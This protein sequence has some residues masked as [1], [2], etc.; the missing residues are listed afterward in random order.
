MSK[1]ELPLCGF[2]F[3][4]DL[5][6]SDVDIY[7]KGRPKRNSWIGRSLTLLYAGIY[8]FFFIFRVVRMANKVDV[9]FYDIYAFNGQPPYMKINNE[10]F[11]S[12]FALLHPLT[13]EPYVNPSIY[14]VKMTYS[15]GVKVGAAFNFETS[16]V[17]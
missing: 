17:E 8:I 13:Q 2:F 14:N 16:N 12:G 6:G 11:R 7:Y 5:F 10:I 9:T 4:I 1:D 3:D 15:T